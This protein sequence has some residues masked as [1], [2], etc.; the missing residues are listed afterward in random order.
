LRAS[1]GVIAVDLRGL[2]EGKAAVPFSGIPLMH[3][4]HDILSGRGDT[5][6]GKEGDEEYS[7]HCGA[8]NRP[9]YRQAAI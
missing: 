9:F 3:L 7:T 4:F 2:A 8:R 6:P 1:Q 5:Q